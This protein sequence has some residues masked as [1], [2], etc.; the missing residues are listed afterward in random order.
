MD[1]TEIYQITYNG[2]IYYIHKYILE[3]YHYFDILLNGPFND[4][5]LKSKKTCNVELPYIIDFNSMIAFFYHGIMIL[6]MEV[7]NFELFLQI[8]NILS[9]FQPKDI[10]TLDLLT[11]SFCNY[12]SLS[13]PIDVTIDNDDNYINKVNIQDIKKSNLNNNHKITL[14]SEYIN[15][16][17]KYDLNI[18][19]SLY[20]FQICYIKDIKYPDIREFFSHYD[21]KINDY[22]I[23]LV[24]IDDISYKNNYKLKIEIDNKEIKSVNLYLFY[25]DMK[26]NIT[27]YLS[28][29]LAE[30][31]IQ[32]Q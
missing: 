28:E 1:Y 24:K 9:F 30:L 23:S 31:L 21:L 7:I 15:K 25:N 26:L 5:N 16:S 6:N 3:K 12:K 2:K 4:N 29:Y 20:E 10:K 14:I 13:N 17:N 32:K 18:K 11:F 27:K 22:N 19:W 8:Y